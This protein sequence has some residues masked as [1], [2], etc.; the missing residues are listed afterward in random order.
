MRDKDVQ[1]AI[2]DPCGS[3][4]LHTGIDS[5]GFVIYSAIRDLHNASSAA[6]RCF[7]SDGNMVNSRPISEAEASQ[8]LHG[9]RGRPKGSLTNNKPRFLSIKLKTLRMRNQQ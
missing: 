1:F 3:S 6:A 5:N 7:I 2:D 8:R 9:R 4:S